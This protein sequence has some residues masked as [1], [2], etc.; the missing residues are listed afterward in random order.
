MLRV[1]ARYTVGVGVA[2]KSSKRSIEEKSRKERVGPLELVEFAM[3]VG[4]QETFIAL[5]SCF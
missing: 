1:F 2:G 5:T 3:N 4:Y